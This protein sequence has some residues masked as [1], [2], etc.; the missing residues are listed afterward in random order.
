[1]ERQKLRGDLLA[2]TVPAPTLLDVH[3]IAELLRV[4]EAT[5][6]RAARDGSF[7]KPTV[8]MG[9]HSFRWLTTTYNAWIKD[10]AERQQTAVPDFS[11][12]R[13]GRG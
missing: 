12:R 1:M 9:H 11:K 10:Q 13:R 2:E 7:P 6:Y 3:D 5:V 8:K 4:S